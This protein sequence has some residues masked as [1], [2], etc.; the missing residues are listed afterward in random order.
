MNFPNSSTK[1]PASWYY[2]TLYATPE[3][4]REG[5]NDLVR[6]LLSE[7][8]VVAPKI[9]VVVLNSASTLVVQYS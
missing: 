3:G 5:V 6:I 7:G 2:L 1:V 4:M 8:E 9:L